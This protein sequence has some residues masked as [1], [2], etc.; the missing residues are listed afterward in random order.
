MSLR[1]LK[2]DNLIRQHLVWQCRGR[3]FDYCVY[4]SRSVGSWNIDGIERC[5]IRYTGTKHEW[6]IV[7]VEGDNE[8]ACS[9]DG[10]Y[11]SKFTAA[12]AATLQETA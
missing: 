11:S 2:A 4:K 9:D 3:P 7:P 8:N 1:V 12:V 5:I 6:W 10:P